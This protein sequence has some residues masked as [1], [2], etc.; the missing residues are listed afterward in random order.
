[1]ATR[2]GSLVV[3]GRRS[4]AVAYWM[5]HT[6]QMSPD[7]IASARTQPW[8]AALEALVHTAAY[9]A[10][11][12]ENYMVGQ[13]LPTGR[14]SS[15]RIPT[16]IMDGELSQPWQHHGVDALAALLPA[17]QRHTLTGAA[18]GARPDQLEPVLTLFLSPPGSTS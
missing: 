16:L 5:E 1:L 8:W 12:M 4:D 2:I 11:I 3:A 10:T 9:D 7:E 18:H 15:V 6:V 13:P 17:A 14:W